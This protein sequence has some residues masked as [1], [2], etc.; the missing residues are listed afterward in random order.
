[1]LSLVLM[2]LASVFCMGTNV[3]KSKENL[4]D[5]TGT[6]DGGVLHSTMWPISVEAPNG[7]VKFSGGDWKSL[8]ESTG[9]IFLFERTETEQKGD[10][11]WQRSHSKWGR[12]MGA[13]YGPSESVML[14]TSCCEVRTAN[15]GHG[16]QS[17]KLQRG[18][19]VREMPFRVRA[20]ET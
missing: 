7:T 8:W 3:P 12:K 11:S 20:G 1:M 17:E 18:D 10:M 13:P 16:S 19:A 2:T 6:Q 15:G 5:K 14:C 9:I 4:P